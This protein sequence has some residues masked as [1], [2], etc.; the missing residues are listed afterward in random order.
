MIRHPYYLANYLIDSSFCVLSGNPYL[1]VAYPFLFF[2]SYG[3]TLRKEE[4]FLASKYGDEFL[5]DCF[6]IPQL[7]PDK[8]S[9]ERCR[10][11]FEGF[12]LKR[13]T[14]KEYAR[15]AR[16]CS[17][18]FAIM[19]IHAANLHELRYLLH[20]TRNAYDG[21]SFMLLAAT[22]F[23]LSLIFMLMDRNNR[24]ERESSCY[25]H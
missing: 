19:L 6:N 2:W 23:F 10:A 11:L 18:G 16:F 13:I 5:N 20:P 12:S 24:G 4:K 7:F 3:P 21:F 15:I 8:S 14:L 1:V 25:D 17:S 9:L 22:F